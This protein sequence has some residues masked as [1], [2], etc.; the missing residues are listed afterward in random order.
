M[1]NR[2]TAIAIIAV[3]IVL[4]AGCDSST[5]GPAPDDAL[6]GT[7]VAPGAELEL[8]RSYHPG[9]ELAS[10][11]PVDADGRRQGLW[12]WYFDNGRLRF[13]GWYRDGFLDHGSEWIERNR[14]GS[15]RYHRMDGRHPTGG[16]T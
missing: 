2:T 9:G 7:D 12:E 1:S 3:A 4:L 8:L 15:V 16:P 13:R 14:D 6:F 11:G 10:E 5:S